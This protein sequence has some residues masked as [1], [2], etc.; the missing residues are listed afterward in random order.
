[1]KAKRL[2]DSYDI[3]DKTLGPFEISSEYALSAFKY[4]DFVTLIYDKG[5]LGI[6]V[7]AGSSMFSTTDYKGVPWRYLIGIRGIYNCFFRSN[8]IIYIRNNE[9]DVVFKI[10]VCF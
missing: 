6:H 3:Q 1:M 2:K 9:F 8:G 10:H 7:N 5:D 4:T